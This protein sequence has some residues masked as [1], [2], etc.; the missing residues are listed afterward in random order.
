MRLSGSSKSTR[1]EKAQS[2]LKR[3]GLEESMDKYPS[4]LSG[5]MSQRVAI[6]RALAHEPELLVL[7]EPFG[8]LDEITRLDLGIH[9][10][11]MLSKTS[12]TT[13]LVTHSIDEAV[14]ISTRIL[15]LSTSPARIILD[16]KNPLSNLRQEKTLTERLFV[17]VRNT[18]LQALI[19]DRK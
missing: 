18:V 4:E 6:A 8:Q 16:L 19:S 10:Q 7:D 17:E 15:V 11:R 12:I 14:L 5:G 2:W 1:E 13:V 3:F 9:L